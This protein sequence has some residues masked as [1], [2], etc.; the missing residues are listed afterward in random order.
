MHISE[1]LVATEKHRKL[2]AVV[3]NLFNLCRHLISANAYHYLMSSS[4]QYARRTYDI[5]QVQ[6]IKN[7]N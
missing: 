4:W 7:N 2:H 3:Y 1:I 5:Q 6:E